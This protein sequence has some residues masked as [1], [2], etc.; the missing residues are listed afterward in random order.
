[1]SNLSADTWYDFEV[2]RRVTESGTITTRAE[3]RDRVIIDVDKDYNSEYYNPYQRKAGEPV[4]N[5][6]TW[7]GGM[8]CAARCSEASGMWNRQWQDW[9][10]R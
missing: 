2:R 1:M 5:P 4:P 6:A 10:S 8:R 3:A 9:Q 7:Q